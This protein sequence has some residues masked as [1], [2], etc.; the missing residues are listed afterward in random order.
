MSGELADHDP[1]K[2]IY[3]EHARAKHAIQRTYLGAWLAIL[4]THFSPLVL[5]DG[6]AGR[7]HYEGGED[8]SPLLFFK[9]AAEA[10]DSGRPTRQDRVQSRRSGANPPKP[11]QAAPRLIH[12]RRPC[13]VPVDQV[14]G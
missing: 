10:V 3:T 14:P 9:R 7:G 6:F 8:G 11:A 13:R 5:F 1:R 4:G 2:W 12:A